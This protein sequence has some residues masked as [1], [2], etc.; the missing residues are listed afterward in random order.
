[1]PIIDTNTVLSQPLLHTR[2]YNR[3]IITGKENDVIRSIYIKTN[4]YYI[5]YLEFSILIQ[6]NKLIDRQNNWGEYVT[7]VQRDTVNSKNTIFVDNYGSLQDN[8][9]YI[10]TLDN[11]IELSNL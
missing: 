1:M 11:N 9:E 6:K 2:F 7:L 10:L 3:N 4:D 5:N 8:K